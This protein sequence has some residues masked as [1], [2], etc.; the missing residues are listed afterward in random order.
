M[1]KQTYRGGCGLLLGLLLLTGCS[2][3]RV[4]APPPLTHARYTSETHNDFGVAYE[5]EGELERARRQYRQAVDK[6][7]TNHVAWTN[8]G[9]VLYRSGRG[10]EAQDAY[11]RALA[12]APGYGPAVNN[13]AMACLE[14]EPPRPGLALKILEAHLAL[15]EPPY[16]AAVLETLDE[17]RE[18]LPAAD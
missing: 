11:R 10:R 14:A 16:R 2:V 4:D 6:D 12:L 13:L 15:V 7:E 18:A 17:A 8:L 9:N 5:N 1:K 3:L